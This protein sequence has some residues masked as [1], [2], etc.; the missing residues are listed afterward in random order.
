M[1]WLLLAC[2]ALFWAGNFVVGRL[3]AGEAG[4]LTLSIWRWGL[5]TLIILPFA[6]PR[7]WRQRELIAQHWKLLSFL[8]VF[9][10][11]SFNTLL[12][13]GLQTTTATN[14]LIINSSIPV[15]I[16]AFGLVLL[17]QTPTLRSLLGI[18]T[19]CTGVIWLVS[20]GDLSTLL[21]RGISEGDLWILGSSV[22]WAIYSLYLRFRPAD[23]DPIA[24][25][26]FMCIVGTTAI[27]LVRLL[28]PF[29]ETALPMQPHLLAAVGF[30]AL[31]P[32]LG[33]YLCWNAGLA[34]VGAAR[35]G[36]M[37]HLMPVFGLTLATLF[38]GERM[39]AHHWVGGSLIAA[40]LLIALLPYKV[41]SNA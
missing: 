29:D 22:V 6:W 25:L 23:L 13:I 38:L 17:K 12:Y 8:A 34:R 40:G 26:G 15:L 11:A 7:I 20:Q 32:S 14:A 2:S 16:I 3:V 5:A 33:A 1:A 28:N 39:V 36:Q 31:F 18:L 41:K 10:V 37:I 27:G 4:P 21:A 30:F 24:F 35:G 19:S 9:S